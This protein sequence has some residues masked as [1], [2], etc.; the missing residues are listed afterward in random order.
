MTECSTELSNA[1]IVWA[2]SPAGDQQAFKMR[3]NGNGKHRVKFTFIPDS[4]WFKN[5]KKQ[6]V[7]FSVYWVEK[8]KPVELKI[9][10]KGDQ[11]H[12]FSIGKREWKKVTIEIPSDSS[13]YFYPSTMFEE[14]S[15][16]NQ[17]FFE[18][19]G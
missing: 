1:S 16:D 8:C 2:E 5:A 10:L 7:S 14:V 18:L 13:I 19:W 11:W 6:D 3:T 15:N 17:G 12:L 9:D 4:I